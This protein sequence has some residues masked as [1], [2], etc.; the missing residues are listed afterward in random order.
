AEYS[1]A[2][3]S[4]RGDQAYRAIAFGESAAKAI[5]QD[6][7]LPLMPR[8][9][10]ELIY[11]APYRD[12]FDLYSP[13]LGVD[14]RLVLSL[15]RQESRFNPSVKSSASARGLLQFITE[16]AKKLADEEGLKHFEL[17]DVYTPEVAI[18]LA[19]RYV[20]DLQKLFPNNPPAVLA[21]YNT[22]EQNV[23]RW[24][25]RARS[26]DPDRLLTEIAIPETKDYVAKV[27]SS[28]RAYVRLYTEDLKP[29]AR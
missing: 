2:V 11:P 9:L 29:R 16:T 18:R 6:Y 5:P 8:D 10:V 25:A 3:Y 28:Y 24:I 21:A 20:A 17:D 23:E 13:R 12:A 15:A 7:Q 26:S 19:V 27:M 4:N 22:A 14:P 1:M